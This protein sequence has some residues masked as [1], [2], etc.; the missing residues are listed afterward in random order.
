[1]V[2]A[3]V[4]SASGRS[5]D[6]RNVTAGKPRIVDS[7]AI[8]MLVKDRSKANRVVGAVSIGGP[9]F[10]LGREKLASFAE[11]LHQAISQLEQIW[12]ARAHANARG[13]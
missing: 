4:S 8:A 7:S 11:P 13:S 10:R 5:I 9:T 6:E 3:P 1:M 2:I 12:P